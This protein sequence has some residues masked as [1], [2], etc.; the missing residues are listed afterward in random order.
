MLPTVHISTICLSLVHPLT[1]SQMLSLHRPQLELAAEMVLFHPLQ[2]SLGSFLNNS[3]SG[4]CC[5]LSNPLRRHL[6]DIIHPLPPSDSRSNNTIA[7]CYNSSGGGSDS[8]FCCP[9]ARPQRNGYPP[10]RS[11]NSSSTG[12][13]ATTPLT[14]ARPTGYRCCQRWV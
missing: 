14:S 3:R 6:L 5:S 4:S 8:L 1:R 13:P 2:L 9:L 10:F 12:N 11:D 7:T